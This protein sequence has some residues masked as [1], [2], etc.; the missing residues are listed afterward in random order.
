MFKKNLENQLL[1][2]EGNEMQLTGDAIY[3]LNIRTQVKKH[4]ETA[5]LHLIVVFLKVNHLNQRSE[6][7]KGLAVFLL[8]CPEK[9]EGSTSTHLIG[10]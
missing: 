5:Q 6:Y 2:G 1:G 10:S 4:R 7:C 3:Q 8:Q 9:T